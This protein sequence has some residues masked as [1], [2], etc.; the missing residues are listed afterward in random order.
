MGST[1]VSLEAGRSLLHAP[2][3]RRAL[4]GFGLS[5]LLASLLGAIL[6][7]WGYHLK[8]D[9]VTIGNYFLSF[10]IGVLF[11]VEVGRRLL[12]RKGVGFVLILGSGLASAALVF[13]A[14]A[15]PPLPDL[16]RMGGLALVGLAMGLL[17][18]GI[19]QAISTIYH[20]DPAAT[21]N[22][23]GI[24]FGLGC[25]LITLLVAGTFNSYGVTS[26]LVLAALPPALFTALFANTVFPPVEIPK[27][28]T[29]REA[30]RDFRSRGAVLLALLLFFQFG[31]EWSIAGWLPIF[32]IHRL[33]A[34][35]EAA[36]EILAAY[37]LALML[38]R[39]AAIAVLRRMSHGRVLLSSAAAAMFGCILLLA[40]DNQF[41]AVIGILLTGAGFATIYPLVS[42]KIGHRFTYYHPGLFNGIFCFALIGAML[43]PAALGYAA[44]IWGVGAVMVLPLAG[45]IMVFVL[46]LLI[47]LESK[48]GG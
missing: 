8:F 1:Q 41:G 9:F 28:P 43:A 17:N 34:S 20:L 42:E 23:G 18:S 2:S 47:W 26:I 30:L 38:G 4:A 29:F 21:V 31:N 22:L 15:P 10:A 32:L 13:L 35:P 7:A 36:L 39:I 48:I 45:T 33:G 19:F 25:L 37:W 40:T 24:V 14:F 6:P 16:W 5:G 44:G 12:P 46:V 27:G 11:S 3:A